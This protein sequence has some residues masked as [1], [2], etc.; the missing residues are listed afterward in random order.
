MYGW[1]AAFVFLECWELAYLNSSTME[2]SL[3][4]CRDTRSMISLRN[5]Y[6]ENREPTGDRSLNDPCPEVVF[7]ACRTSNLID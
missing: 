3:V 4:L 6:S 1:I 5:N 7:S 2:H